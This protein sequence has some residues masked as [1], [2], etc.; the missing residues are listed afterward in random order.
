MAKRLGN[1]AT[2]QDLRDQGVPAAAFRHFVFSTHYRKQLN[3]S[4]DAL[5]AS[6]E[7]VRRIADF[8]ERLADATAATPELEKVADEAEAEFLSALYDDL[9]APIALG[10]LFTFIRR[11]N[12]E[13]DRNGVDRRALER[14]REVFA[15]IN[16]VLDVVPEAADSDPEL[17]QWIEEKLA[18]RK[19]A[20]SRREF[21]QAD[22]IRAE[23]EGRGI[24]IEDG[25]QGTKWKKLR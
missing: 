20:R 9:N 17:M 2:V 11:A 7:G 1:V 14:A 16:S 22:A 21:A 5:E 10:A 19:N 25:P 13:L 24:A 8:A 4:G 6:M 23:I 3:M 18:A 15:R 12:A